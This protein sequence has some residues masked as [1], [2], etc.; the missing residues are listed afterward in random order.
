M[1]TDDPGFL[2]VKLVAVVKDG[3][4]WIEALSTVGACDHE[5]EISGWQH[6]RVVTTAV[7]K[8]RTIRVLAYIGGPTSDVVT[9]F[10]GADRILTDGI[11]E[12]PEV[13]LAAVP[14][15]QSPPSKE[16]WMAALKAVLK[17]ANAA[18]AT[19]KA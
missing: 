7:L 9:G 1:K 8:E 14:Q 18:S 12:V 3:A 17:D 11:V 5:A 16:A 4:A 2:D 6:R 15:L 10:V 13:S 19:P